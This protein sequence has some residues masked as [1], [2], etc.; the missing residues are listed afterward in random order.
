MDRRTYEMR[1]VPQTAVQPPMRV[2]STGLYER[3]YSTVSQPLPKASPARKRWFTLE[4]VML[5]LSMVVGAITH[6]YHLFLYPLYITDEGIYMERA[7]SV[8]RQGMLSPYT[9]YYDHAP[10]GW[11]T[12]ATWTAVLP[13]Q[14]EAFGNAINTGRVL[15]LL[16]HVASTYLLFMSTRRL[17]GSVLAAVVACFFFNVSPLAI[18]Y[19]RQVLLDN[20]M[21]FW[22]LLSLYLATSDDRRILTPLWSGL[23]LGVAVITKENAIFFVPVIGYLLYGKVRPRRNYR[24]ALTYWLFGLVAI[25]SLY[26]L[27]A[28][29]KN[30]LFPAH[31][32]FDLNTPPAGHVSLLYTIWQQLHRNQGGIMDTHSSFWTFSLGA[33][34]PKDAFLLAA[35]AA[36]TLVNLLLGLRDRKRYRGELV[37]SLLSVVYIFYLVRGSVMLEF[38]VIPLI[39][40]L[41]MNIAMVANRVLRVIPESRRM[42]LL[43]ASARSLIVAACFAVLVLPTGSYVLVHDQYGK[44]VPHDLYKLSLTTMQQEQL[45]F[46]RAHIPPGARV[47]MDDDLW[48]QLR[49]VR[50]YYPFAVSHWNASSDPDV[51]DKIFQ[52]NWQNIDYIVMSNKMLVAMQQN[53]GDGG[54]NYILTALQHAQPIWQLT[55]GNVSLAVYQVQK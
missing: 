50:P 34:L 30:E 1:A 39:P 9:Y 44:T 4:H 26:F 47:I 49:D 37:A 11:L 23:A 16:I 55:Q 18:F 42:P 28:I 21:V 54:E 20:L 53:N 6:G 12:I 25:V 31:M 35:G 52:N 24:F 2:D 38:Y 10:G 46:I 48:V 29:L 13:H 51:R 27:L 43:S 5:L 15:M 33:W 22:V 40:F 8:L 45:S 3:D 36:A 14:F 32:S 19:Q 17:S 41:A 7:W